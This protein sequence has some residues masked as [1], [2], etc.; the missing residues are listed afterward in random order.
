MVIDKTK[1]DGDRKIRLNTYTTDTTALDG[2]TGICISFDL[3]F[4]DQQGNHCDRKSIWIHHDC[5]PEL[6]DAIDRYLAT[7]KL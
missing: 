4:H 2:T 5:L 6:R 1:N 3:Q 7:G